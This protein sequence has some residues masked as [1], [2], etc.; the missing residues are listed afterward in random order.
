VLGK[1]YAPAGNFLESLPAKAKKKLSP[2]WCGSSASIL[3]TRGSSKRPSRSSS[4]WRKTTPTRFADVGTVAELVHEDAPRTSSTGSRVKPERQR[5]P[6]RR[7]GWKYLL[8]MKQAKLV[9][10]LME[11][12][13]LDE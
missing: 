7:A 1:L 8:Y 13:K 11:E 2:T 5:G 3:P 6:P 12:L 10:K 4:P 9:A